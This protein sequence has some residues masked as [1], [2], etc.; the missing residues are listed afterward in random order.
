MFSAICDNV[1][2]IFERDPTARGVAKTL[3][4]Y[5]GLHAVLFYWISHWFWQHGVFFVRRFISPVGMFLTGTEIH[6]GAKIGRKSFI[7]HGIGVV[8]SETTEIDDNV[9][10]HHHWVTLGGATW[11]KI[12]RSPTFGNNLVID[13]GATI[14][15]PLKI[16]DNKGVGADAVVPNNIP[17]NMIVAG[18]PDKVVFRIAG[19]KC[20]QMDTEFMP[21]PHPSR[22]PS[23]SLR[24]ERNN[25]KR[26]WRRRDGVMVC[27]SNP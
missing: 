8:I 26:S 7:D 27:D 19:G 4:C 3:F 15:G 16:S 12:K 13:T 14:L 6:R 1:S 17:A 18:I 22:G 21:I 2:A 23:P 25:W 10:L 5:P 20:I 24:R 11:K 9:T